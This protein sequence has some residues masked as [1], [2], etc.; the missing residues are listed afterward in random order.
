MKC[1]A[2][3]GKARG[4][5]WELLQEDRQYPLGTGNQLLWACPCGQFQWTSYAEWEK[6]QGDTNER[7]RD[8]IFG[9][10]AKLQDVP[11][12]TGEPGAFEAHTT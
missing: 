8:A 7:E 3:V 4:H 11:Q 10:G 5:D 2:N 9:G 1:V 6:R 12:H